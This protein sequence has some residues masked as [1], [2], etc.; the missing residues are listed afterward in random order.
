MKKSSFNVANVANSLQSAVK[1]VKATIVPP[2]E[3]KEVLGEFIDQELPKYLNDKR[4]KSVSRYYRILYTF[5][6]G[7][8]ALRLNDGTVWHI[9]SEARTYPSRNE[10]AWAIMR[11]EAFPVISPNGEK[12]YLYR[13]SLRHSTITINESEWI[14][15][16]EDWSGIV[17]ERHTS[18]PEVVSHHDSRE[19]LRKKCKD[20]WKGVGRL[21]FPDE[22]IVCHVTPA[23][24]IEETCNPFGDG[25]WTITETNCF[26]APYWIW[27]GDQAAV[28]DTNT[29]TISLYS[30]DGVL[31]NEIFFD[32]A[33][34]GIAKSH[35][36]PGAIVAVTKEAVIKIETSKTS[37]HQVCLHKNPLVL[38]NGTVFA[39]NNNGLT[40]V[41]EPNEKGELELVDCATTI[42]LPG[43]VEKI[44]VCDRSLVVKC[45]DVDGLISFFC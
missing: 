41:I 44:F 10:L 18:M 7:C 36:Y 34:L 16:Y 11:G 6:K 14:V 45:V 35:Q 3:T 32:S 5:P 31:M 40:K 12:V 22:K 29:G 13:D 37:W 17:K 15:S 19:Y 23:G 24:F 33:L 20:G 43:K 2:M 8:I 21:A 42:G 28:A 9:P 4:V 25:G 38:E 30:A 39:V 27:E 26:G 1:K